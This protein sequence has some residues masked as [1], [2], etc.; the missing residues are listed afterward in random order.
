M[1]S[2]YTK[3]LIIGYILSLVVESI[4]MGFVQGNWIGMFI[5]VLLFYGLIISISFY[6]TEK[7]INKLVHFL[8]F[9]F[10][11]LQLEWFLFQPDPFSG[12]ILIVILVNLAMFGHWATIAFAPRMLTDIENSEKDKKLFIRT[13]FISMLF[14]FS[15]GIL[16]GDYSILIFGNVLVYIALMYSYIKYIKI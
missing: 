15:I 6:A 16:I 14:V 9:G 13:Y 10:M 2:R 3:F 7:K 11:G 1:R 12:H 5:T 4:N 8:I